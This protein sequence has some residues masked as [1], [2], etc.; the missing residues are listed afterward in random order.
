MSLISSLPEWLVRASEALKAGD[1]EGWMKIYSPE[2]IHEFPFAPEGAPRRLVGRDAIAAY[3][4]Q[5][6]ARIR[7]GTFSDIRVREAEDELIVEATGHHRNIADDTP[8]DI[9][10]VWFITRRDGHVTHFRD[11]MN[12]LQLR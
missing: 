8:R 3:M 6:P 7:F 1:I 12:P 9:C 4:Q 2:A 10:Y 5:L 11:Y